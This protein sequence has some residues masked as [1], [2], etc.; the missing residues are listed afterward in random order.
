MASGGT[1]YWNATPARSA[2]HPLYLLLHVRPYLVQYV[3][4]RGVIPAVTRSLRYLAPLCLSLRPESPTLVSGKRRERHSLERKTTAGRCARKQGDEYR[5]ALRSSCRH[6][7]LTASNWPS[8]GLESFKGRCIQP[9]AART[10]ALIFTAKLA[11]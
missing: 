11:A 6:R 8:Q 9:A 4:G 2:T 5:R 1:L 7:L 3:S 10:E